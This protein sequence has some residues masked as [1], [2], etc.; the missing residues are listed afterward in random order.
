MNLKKCPK[1]T[2][3]QFVRFGIVGLSNTALSYLINVAA[4]KILES[5]VLKWDYILANL[6]A[7]FISVLWSF[8]WNSRFVFHRQDRSRKTTLKT[9]L[10]TYAAYGF[11]GILLN[12]IF[13]WLWIVQLGVSKYLAPLLN[14]VISVPTNF[15]L[16][17]FWAFRG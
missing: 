6:L 1:E 17:K 7:F 5:L 2:A 4:L 13:S 12:N 15:L 8:Y 3:V 10:K 14:L 9:L 11:S 16:N